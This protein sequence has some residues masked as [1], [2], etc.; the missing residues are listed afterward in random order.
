[1]RIISEKYQPTQQAKDSLINARSRVFPDEEFMKEWYDNYSKNHINRLSFDL[2]YLQAEFPEDTSISVLELG[3]TPPILTTAIKDKGYRVTGLDMEPDRFK[4]CIDTNGLEVVKGSIGQESLPFEDATF[5]AVIMNEVF[6]HLNANLITVIEDIKRVMV[7]G[8]KLFISTP[9]LRSMVGIR[10]FL[11]RG[12]AYSCCGEI[13]E[14]YDKISK[15]GHMG[16]VREYTPTELIVFL[17]KLGLEVQTL[18]Y[19]GKYPKKY[20]LIEYLFPKLRP[21]FSVVAVKSQ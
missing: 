20:R 13:Y 6:E 12:K 3:S 8:G 18:I 9:N 4:S 10:N 1:M 21:F 14:E 17:E 5:H 11:F 16:H 2:E 7:P 15:Y 19:R